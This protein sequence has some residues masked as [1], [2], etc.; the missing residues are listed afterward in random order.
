MAGSIMGKP[1]A[2]DGAAIAPDGIINKQALT[3]KSRWG[4]GTGDSQSS[5]KR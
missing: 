3:R 1:D 4:A 2:T 5:P